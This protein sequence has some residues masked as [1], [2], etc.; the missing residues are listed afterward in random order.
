MSTDSTA[1]SRGH[2]K[3]RNPLHFL[4]VVHQEHVQPAM[5]VVGPQNERILQSNGVPLPQALMLGALN[6]G[7]VPQ[8][9]APRMA[10]VTSGEAVDDREAAI[11]GAPLNRN[12]LTDEPWNVAKTIRPAQH[13]VESVR[14]EFPFRGIAQHPIHAF[15]F[16]APC[17]NA[18]HV[19]ALELLLVR[20]GRKDDH[21]SIGHSGFGIL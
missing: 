11:A 6:S 10:K 16:Q 20:I 9:Q 4:G 21:A 12:T 19:A 8:A 14:V 13:G 2:L 1:K 7:F 5:K 15:P 3:L 17:K 18:S